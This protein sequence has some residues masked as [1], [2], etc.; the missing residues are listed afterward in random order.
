MTTA[1]DYRT[2]L[3]PRIHCRG[4]WFLW[5]GEHYD[6]AVIR[7]EGGAW[8]WKLST[9]GAMLAQPGPHT[10]QQRTLSAAVHHLRTVVFAD[11]WEKP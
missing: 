7:R 1:A 10:G 9:A 11:R 5:T 6:A 3:T 4:L 2:T 8:R